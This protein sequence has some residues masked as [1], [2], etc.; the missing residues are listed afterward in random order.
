[1][2]LNTQVGGVWASDGLADAPDAI[3]KW[4]TLAALH[5]GAVLFQAVD[6]FRS[7]GGAP[8]RA[9]RAVI[10]V[11]GELGADFSAVKVDG[12]LASVRARVLQAGGP[13]NL[14]QNA[15]FEQDGNAAAP[16]GWTATGT[17]ASALTDN[18]SV[19]GT[20]LYALKV[21]F[22]GASAS[23]G[24]YQTLTGLA[25]GRWYTLAASIRR[26]TNVGTVRAVVTGDS[27]VYGTLPSLGTAMEAAY[28]R[29]SATFLL[30][31]TASGT[32]SVQLL[33]EATPSG[34]VLF[35]L[36]QLEEGAPASAFRERGA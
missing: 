4:D 27:L 12:V 32:V 16:T 1:L 8:R 33:G 10:D 17:G 25:V 2:L 5:D 11:Q 18:A 3:D 19:A 9:M 36:I 34:Y 24:R 23:Y 22:D 20:G 21:V 14:L 13:E 28:G 26:Q 29:Y 6:P 15:S 30:P 7:A 35:D 31:A